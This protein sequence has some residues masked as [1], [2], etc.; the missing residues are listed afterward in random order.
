M[1]TALLEVGA[2]ARLDSPIVLILKHFVLDFDTVLARDASDMLILLQVLFQV[3][4]EELVGL[5]TAHIVNSTPVGAT[6][7]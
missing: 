4:V 2:V 1:L 3:R 7:A 5:H 6:G